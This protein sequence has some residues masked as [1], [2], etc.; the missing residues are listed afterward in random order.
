MG[1]RAEVKRR[2]RETEVAVTLELDGSGRYQVHTG[3]GFFDH[4]LSLVAKHGLLDLEVRARG[5]LEV[6]Y[7][8]TVEDVGIC[9]GEALKGALGEARGIRRFASALLPMDEALAMMALDI[10]GRPFLVYKVGLTGKVGDFDLEL[11]EVFF[12]GFST[13]GAVTLHVN[14][15]YGQ[16]LHHCCEAL[17]KG[18]GLLL[19]E[20]T[21]LEP[22]L[23]GP[24]STKGVL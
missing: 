7:H 1:R 3:I 19:R 21:R 24:P 17:F 11:A 5:D 4:M 9:M 15:L 6:D 10:S 14:L 13:H 2:T 12:R 23:E 8:H 22:R 20:A 16:N 18:F